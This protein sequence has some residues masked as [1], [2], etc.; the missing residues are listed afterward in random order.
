MNPAQAAG[1]A[2]LQNQQR[3]TDYP[4]YSSVCFRADGT[5][6]TE[7]GATWTQYDFAAGQIRRAFAYAKRGPGEVA[8]F[9]TANDGL[10]TLAETNLVEPH[11]TI[12]GQ[13][14]EIQGIAI[15]FKPAM[16]DG[17]RFV[18]AR[19]LA[20]LAA[21]VSVKFSLNGDENLFPLGTLQQ[22]PG[23]GGLTGV[24]NDDLAFI[25]T[26][27]E[28]ADVIPVPQPLAENIGQPMPFGSNGLPSRGN[29]YRLPSGVIWQ[30]DGAADSLLN[31]I[32]RNERAFN[33]RT[34]GTPERHQDPRDGAHE[35]VSVGVVL[36]V[37]L[38]AQV[39]GRR[40]KAA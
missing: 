31:V 16:T 34:G 14:V 19:V 20:Q 11:K 33:V 38:I 21:N 3:V 18:Q 5:S 35:P 9:T 12:G 13:Q 28:S 1:L 37:Q 26:T 8:G 32:F 30:P 15:G 23:A 10:M 7:A 2:A 27:W 24:Y 25:P 29:F 17:H 39:V 4:Y 40:T 6:V 36:Y 22:V